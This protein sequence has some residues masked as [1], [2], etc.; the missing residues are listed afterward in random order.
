METGCQIV[1]RWIP[2]MGDRRPSS[3]CHPPQYVSA[4]H[5]T[6]AEG[7]REVHLMR[8]LAKP[9]KARPRGR[10]THHKTCGVPDFPQRDQ[11]PLPQH[12]LAEK[13]AQSTTL[14]R[15]EA[16][17]DIL[18]SMRNQLHRQGYPTNPRRMHQRLLQNPGLG[19]GGGKTHMMRLSW[20]PGRP[21]SRHSRLPMCWE[22]DNE[23][24]SQ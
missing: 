4:H 5:Q 8:L 14:W 18:S 7:G 9:T 2:Q 11:R 10:H 6:G 22:S 1:L 16:I 20:R 23:R 19:P 13:I 17:W 24:L 21:T 12:I 3:V 15:K